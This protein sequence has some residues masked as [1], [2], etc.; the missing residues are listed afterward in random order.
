MIERPKQ[1]ETKDAQT[2]LKRDREHDHARDDRHQPLERGINSDHAGAPDVPE[3][4]SMDKDR[5][6]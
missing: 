3:E 1:D 6:A 2:P 4:D 5:G